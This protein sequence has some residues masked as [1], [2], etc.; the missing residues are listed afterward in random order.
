M[1]VEKALANVAHAIII[2]SLSWIAA[3]PDAGFQ[4]LIPALGWL[5]QCL[6]PP[7]YKGEVPGVPK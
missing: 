7:D 5:G 2:G 4:W 6:T 3:N 1:N